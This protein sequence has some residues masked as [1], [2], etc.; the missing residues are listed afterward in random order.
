MTTSSIFC[1]ARRLFVFATM[2]SCT[3]S[4]GYERST[5]S[6]LALLPL[7]TT[8]LLRA[9]PQSVI[10][11]VFDDDPQ[12]TAKGLSASWMHSGDLAAVKH[13]TVLSEL[14]LG[15]STGGQQAG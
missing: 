15:V 11:G 12:G 7:L 4:S 10:E 6:L 13:P 1:P 8:E 3:K 9:F 2:Q 14:I 5:V